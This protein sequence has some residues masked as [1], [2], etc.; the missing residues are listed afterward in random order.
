MKLKPLWVGPFKILEKINENALRIDFVDEYKQ[1]HDVINIGYV[2]PWPQ[3]PDQFESRTHVISRPDPIVNEEGEEEWVVE[4]VIDKRYDKRR[5]KW[6]WCVKWK[7]YTE[8]DNTWE[9]YENIYDCEAFE[10]FNDMYPVED[11][12]ENLLTMQIPMYG[13]LVYHTSRSIPKSTRKA[14]SNAVTQGNQRWIR[15]RQWTNNSNTMRP[16]QLS[17]V[18]EGFRQQKRLWTASQM[19]LPKHAA[20]A[21]NQLSDVWFNKNRLGARYTNNSK[22]FCP[23]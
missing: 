4:D 23:I 7:G 12:E 8:F 1:A 19:N 17:N 18:L 21:I 11:R 15:Q 20:F 10:R 3:N 13:E 6:M 9:P 14:I 2:K 5:K 22:Y 16:S